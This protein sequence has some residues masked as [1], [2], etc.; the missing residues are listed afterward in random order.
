[1]AIGTADL[2][3]SDFVINYL[4]SILTRLE[5]KGRSVTEV[6]AFGCPANVIEFHN[7]RRQFNTT[8]CTGPRTLRTNESIYG[9]PSHAH[10]KRRPLFYF[11]A[12]IIGPHARRLLFLGFGHT[13]YSST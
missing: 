11:G 5:W 13:M 4:K 1:M 6:K 9:S 2:T 7:F 10:T 12:L 8:V 3:F